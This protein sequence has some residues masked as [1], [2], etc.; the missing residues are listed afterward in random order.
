MTPLVAAPVSVLVST[1]V[2]QNVTAEVT[3]G[4]TALLAAGVAVMVIV[5]VT[6]ILTQPGLLQWNK[7]SGLAGRSDEGI[8]RWLRESAHHPYL[9]SY[10][11]FPQTS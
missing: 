2:A 10:L 5:I 1:T 7:Q 6:V 3:A 9:Q 11:P 4:V 8:L